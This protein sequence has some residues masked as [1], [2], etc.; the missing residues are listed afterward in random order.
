MPDVLI[1][2][3]P[4]MRLSRLHWPVTVLGHGKRAGIWFQG[5]TLECEGCC[6]KDTWDSSEEKTVPVASVLAWLKKIPLNDLDGVTISG[7]EPFQQQDALRLL[8]QEVREYIGEQRDIIIYSGFAWKKIQRAFSHILSDVDVVI[9]EPY[10]ANG[11]A[12]YLRGSDNQQLHL[13]S[14]LAE[15]RYN[16][17]PETG[18]SM[19][20]H[21]DGKSL[22][23]IGIPKPGE[24]E[25]IKDKLQKKGLQLEGAS[26]EN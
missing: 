11:E 23:M 6:S 7:G 2:A 15:S 22:W 16:N 13:L 3:Q 5:C 9:S 24:L 26:W 4:F 17:S 1:S 12:K 18:P 20:V 25:N 19:Q 8:V 21:F 14:P 10:D